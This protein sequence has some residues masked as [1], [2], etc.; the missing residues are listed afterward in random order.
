MLDLASFSGIPD[1]SS[2]SARATNAAAWLAAM[3]AMGTSTAQ[4]AATLSVAGGTF[5]F[6]GPVFMTHPCIIRG[7]GGSLNSVSKL[8]FPYNGPGIVADW[9]ASPDDPGLATWGKIES[10]DIINEGASSI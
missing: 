6:P 4:R 1:D 5:Y 10:L 3:R 2:Q 8:V 7:E 9:L